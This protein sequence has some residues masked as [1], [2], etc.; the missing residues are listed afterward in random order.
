MS[1]PRPSDSKR[2]SI[3]RA[4]TLRQEQTFENDTVPVVTGSSKWSTLRKAFREPA[5]EFLG[6]AILVIFGTGVQCQVL[7][8]SNPGVASSPKGDYFS[9]C[10]GW[11]V[12]IALGVWVSGGV[13]GG[14]INPA[15]T[16][17]LA[18]FRGFSW[19]KVPSYILAQVL[20]GVV[21]A[22]IVYATYFHAI[23]IF[24][25][26]RGVRSMDTAGLWGIFA[27]P[28]LTNVSCFFSE[29]LGAAIL[30]ITIF[31]MSDKKNLAPPNGLA[32]LV[33]AFVIMG[34][35]VSLGMGTGFG[36]N[37]ARDFGPRLLS[38]M[39]GYGKAVYTFRNQY[40]LWCSIIAPIVG[41]QAGALFYD[42]F[43]YT[44]DDSIMNKS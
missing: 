11:A 25:G 17:S 9:V 29:F 41:A 39:V 32:P 4:S 6:T 1:A 27:A 10:V 38:S 16:L 44:G 5:A 15:I 8:S 34:L 31:A 36:V 23:D 7:L 14:H 24:E 2:W 40:W 3:S 33:L 18:T 13:S 12:G 35:A 28:Y 42:T 21:G 37:P 30:A 26:G 20:G 22:A 19:K 43:L